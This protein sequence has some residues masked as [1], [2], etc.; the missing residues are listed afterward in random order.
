MSKPVNGWTPERRKRQSEAVRTWE[1]WRKST[2][3]KTPEG[4]AVVSRN[5]FAGGKRPQL[6]ELSKQINDGLREHAEWL[7]I[8]AIVDR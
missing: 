4:K 6:R 7:D 3:P 1:P 8:L 5:A 2:G